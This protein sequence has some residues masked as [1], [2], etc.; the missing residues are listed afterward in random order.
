MI[1]Y[2]SLFFLF[3]VTAVKSPGQSDT[4]MFH[5]DLYTTDDGL[6]SRFIQD[7]YQD[8]RG[9][10][11]VS[12]DYGVNRFDGQR[13]EVYNQGK[14]NLQTDNINEIRED[15]AGNLWF[16]KRNIYF[17][18]GVQSWRKISI[19]V[20]D[21]HRNIILSIEDYLD[22]NPPFNWSSVARIE[23]DELYNLW[24]TTV[25]GKI[26]CY[27]DHF[28]EVPIDPSLTAGG[29]LY[30]LPDAGFVILG[31][32]RIIRL[33]EQ[34]ELVYEVDFE[35]KIIDFFS[36]ENGQ[37]VLVTDLE[38]ILYTIDNKGQIALFAGEGVE[39]GQELR[40]G[41][42]GKDSKGRIW[43]EEQENKITLYEEEKYV[44]DL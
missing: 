35:R 28:A 41:R 17:K 31:T 14:Y 16:I 1:K 15:Q 26:Y 25:E 40:V 44:L 24:V 7:I 10:I 8:S 43:L 39:L 20:L 42:I 23:Q 5:H 37:L 9:F 21:Y 34:S 19:D 11:W 29:V 27:T 36:N 30:P 18:N 32:D 22:E 33:N 4:Y 13:F 3:L 12:S 6:S 38:R 2:F